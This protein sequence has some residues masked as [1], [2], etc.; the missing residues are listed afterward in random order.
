MQFGIVT[1]RAGETNA[2]LAAVRIDGL[3][4]CLLP[5]AQAVALLG[6]GDVALA[7]LDVRE[8]LDGIEEGLP[9]LSTLEENGVRVLNPPGV[10]LSTH[11]K[12]LTARALERSGLPHP[13]TEPIG[14]D[15]MPTIRPPLVLKPRFG[16]WGRDVMLCRN[17]IELDRCVRELQSRPWFHTHGALAQE[18][19]PPLGHDLRLVVAAGRVVGAIKRVAA[20]G[21]WRTNLALGARRVPVTPPPA[22][23][24]LAESAARSIGAH[25]VGID[26]LPVGPGRFCVIELNGAVDFGSEY[27]LGPDVFAATLHT[28]ASFVRE[29]ADGRSVVRERLVSLDEHEGIGRVDLGNRR[30]QQFLAIADAS[31]MHIGEL[32]DQHRR[33]RRCFRGA[34]RP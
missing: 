15:A 22:A 31:D 20:S 30:A 27:S 14:P 7:R 17:R 3:Q 28:L 9:A 13:D 10:L 4:V 24:K 19:I 1:H 26:L 25:L 11:D 5:P 6:P 16:S 12:L 32:G 33:T 18:L 23:I 8:T 21:E 29:E 34:R 2:K